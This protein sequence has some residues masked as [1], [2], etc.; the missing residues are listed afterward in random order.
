MSNKDH[1][2]LSESRDVFLNEHKETTKYIAN[3]AL[4]S[5]KKSLTFKMKLAKLYI[6]IFRKSSKSKFKV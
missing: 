1:Q 5:E 3:L 4:V 2:L 6:T